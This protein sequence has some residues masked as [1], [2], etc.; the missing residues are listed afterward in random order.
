MLATARELDCRH[1]WNAHAASARQAGVRSEIV[2]AL[3]EC[4]ELPGL[5]ADEAAVVDYGRE[6]S[7]NR[8]TA[9]RPGSFHVSLQ[10]MQSE[11]AHGR[12]G[13]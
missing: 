3:R 9:S 11:S 2:D 10:P 12:L 8:S 7:S 13:A 1:I 5:A 4:R 6:R